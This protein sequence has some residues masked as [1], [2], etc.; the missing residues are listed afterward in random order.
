MLL[1][2]RQC[3]PFAA[4]GIDQKGLTGRHEARFFTPAVVMKLHDAARIDFREQVLPL[5]TR[6]MAFAYR[7]A[8]QG[9]AIDPD[10]FEP[11]AD[12][13]RAIGEILWPLRRNRE[14][15]ALHEAGLIDVAGG[16]G[17]EVTG[18][19]ARARF[20]IEARY[21]GRT[22]RW[23]ADV[24]VSA[25]LH[26]YSPLT[27]AA[28]LSAALLARGI[29]QPYE[30]S[31]YHPG[32]I[33]I[34][35]GLH[36]IGAD[37]ESREHV[38]A[39]GF[40]VEGAHFY[41]HALPRPGI[42]SRQTRDAERCVLA[43]LDT[44]AAGEPRCAHAGSRRRGAG[45]QSARPA[46]CAGAGVR[47]FGGLGARRLV[48]GDFRGD[49]LDVDGLHGVLG[50]SAGLPEGRERGGRVTEPDPDRLVAYRE[51]RPAREPVVD[52]RRDGRRPARR[53][54]SRHPA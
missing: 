39:I 11:T 35:A 46:A 13:L 28:P 19:D 21:G 4:R 47:R 30:N 51:R 32:G 3:L 8:A 49:G 26:S 45:R 9:A 37:A 33:A 38:W 40:P 16:P 7:G 44:I 54:R 34:D 48:P 12:E 15:V 14:F 1:V 6:E 10:G 43:L 2:S 5:V 24:L 25:R 22:E 53:T 50:D 52:E 42:A 23:F 27:D 18:D 31:G 41:T 17:S 20:R 29:V 36:P